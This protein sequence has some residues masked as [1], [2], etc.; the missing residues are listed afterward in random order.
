MGVSRQLLHCKSI[1]HSQCLKKEVLSFYHC[2]LQVWDRKVWRTQTWET[3][4]LCEEEGA[5][6]LVLLFFETK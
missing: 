1:P 2:G 5:P 3:L 4:K 6:S